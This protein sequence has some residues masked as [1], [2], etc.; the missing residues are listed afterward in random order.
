[1]DIF[2]NPSKY[3]KFYT[4]L[5]ATAGV[6]LF[7]CMPTDTEAAFAVNTNEWYQVLTAFAGS[8][9]VYVVSNKK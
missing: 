1:M 9:G 3:A 5:I 7:A 6:L 2:K 4:A 8:L